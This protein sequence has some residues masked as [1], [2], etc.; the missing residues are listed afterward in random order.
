V[1]QTP[2]DLIFAKEFARRLRPKY[3]QA[4]QQDP[5]KP[6]VQFDEEFAKTLGV[7][8]AALWKYLNNPEPPTPSIRTVVLAFKNYEI[9]IRYEDIDTRQILMKRRRPRHVS[10]Q[11]MELPFFIRASG[12]HI[13]GMKLEP[14]RVS[15]RVWKLKITASQD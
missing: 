7:D 15:R 9:A 3:A 2:E 11:Q 14:Q 8:R 10:E 13:V 12:P 6:K 4:R 1:K 5:G